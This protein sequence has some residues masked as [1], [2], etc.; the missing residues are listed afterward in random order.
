M[1]TCKKRV[2]GGLEPPL[3]TDVTP[4]APRRVVTRRGRI[5]DMIEQ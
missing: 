1:F 3:G 2:N 5:R 4:A